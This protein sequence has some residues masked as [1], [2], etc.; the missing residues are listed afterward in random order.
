MWSD[1][2]DDRQ[3]GVV[4]QAAF[5]APGNEIHNLYLPKRILSGTPFMRDSGSPFPGV[6]FVIMKTI[7]SGSPVGTT[8]CWG[9]LDR[10]ANLPVGWTMADTSMV[11]DAVCDVWN[12]D[13]DNRPKWHDK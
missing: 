13:E 11:L 2:P 7:H 6:A 12:D 4:W 1:L 10:K 3:S 8:E 9:L 5:G